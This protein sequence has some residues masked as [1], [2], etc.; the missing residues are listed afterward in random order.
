M[1]GLRRSGELKRRGEEIHDPIL[2]E[3]NIALAPD[4]GCLEDDCFLFGWHNLAGAIAVSFREGTPY[5]T[6]GAPPK[7]NLTAIIYQDLYH[8]HQK[9]ICYPKV[10]FGQDLG[11]LPQLQGWSNK[12]QRTINL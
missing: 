5:Q 2:P 1:I 12:I 11:F 9:G 6:L 10:C 7:K 4:N 8:H 3:T